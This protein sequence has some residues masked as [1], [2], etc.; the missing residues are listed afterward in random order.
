MTAFTLTKV[1]PI[2]S[3]KKESSSLSSNY[4]LF[5]TDNFW[6]FLKLDTRNGKIWQVQFDVQG[7]N[8]GET[9]LNSLSLVT[10]ENQSNGRF[11]LY[12]TKNTYNFM[13]LDQ[14]DGKVYQVQWS[15]EEKNR[16]VVPIK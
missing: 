8:R 4:Q 10:D 15:Q 9:S 16:I 13:L 14:I 7:N 5:P 3:Q 6:T 11:T 2:Q 12:P 1:V